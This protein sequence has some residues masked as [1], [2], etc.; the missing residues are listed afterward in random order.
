MRPSRG[1]EFE[2]RAVLAPAGALHH[3]GEVER[4]AG[5]ARPREALVGL[6]EPLG[7]RGEQRLAP[8]DPI[9]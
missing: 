6:G 4:P 9:G 2:A 3:L 1:G 5:P 7:E 8:R